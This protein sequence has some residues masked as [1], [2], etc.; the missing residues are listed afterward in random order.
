MVERTQIT[1]RFTGGIADQGEL[2]FYEAGRYRYAAARLLYTL[3]E[4]RQT[5]N[6]KQKLRTFV[7]VNIVT[8]SP[9]AGSFI[10]PVLIQLAPFV[11]DNY[12]R[13]PL[14]KVLC[15]TLDRILPKSNENGRV[16]ALAESLVESHNRYA[17]VALER[18]RTAQAE[19]EERRAQFDEVV[20]LLRQR[21]DDYE[22]LRRASQTFRAHSKAPYRVSDS[23]GPMEFAA[24]EIDAELERRDALSEYADEFDRIGPAEEEEILRRV[25]DILP[26]MTQPLRRS[27]N[28]LQLS[29]ANDNKRFFTV[30]MERVDQIKR[31]VK[32]KPEIFSGNI[33]RYDK[34]QGFGK[35]QI[36]G[37]R[38]RITFH[39]PGEQKVTYRN[40]I[41]E[42]MKLPS[43]EAEYIPITDGT[44]RVVMLVFR[45]FLV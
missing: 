17:S 19:I 27:A 13:M 15:W 35:L 34:T 10:D 16:L 18:E 9:Q 1:F 44:G 33:V 30:N 11:A 3:E 20:R 26:E 22:G 32:G 7:N 23:V 31:R 21:E 40:R 41:L 39:V 45:D 37:Q 43:V 28:Y 12:L 2:N 14:E 36:D 24:D 42:A 25:R 4:F 29:G 5:G 8:K 6:V 38:R